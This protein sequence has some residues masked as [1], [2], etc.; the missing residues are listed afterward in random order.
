MRQQ[1]LQGGARAQAEKMGEFG[2]LKG[3]FR[4]ERDVGNRERDGMQVTM[5][6][7]RSAIARLFFL[8]SY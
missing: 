3:N 5:A 7:G 2:A 4:G 6:A 1:G 8:H